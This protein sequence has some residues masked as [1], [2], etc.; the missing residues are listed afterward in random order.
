[1]DRCPYKKVSSLHILPLQLAFT[2]I[3]ESD[4]TSSA[5]PSVIV[6]NKM[7]DSKVKRREILH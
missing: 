4:T 7:L 3:F 6:Y 2:S 5:E 1:M